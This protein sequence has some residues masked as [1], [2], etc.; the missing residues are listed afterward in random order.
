VVIMS[1]SDVVWLKVPHVD[2]TRYDIW[3]SSGTY[4]R[5]FFDRWRKSPLSFILLRMPCSPPLPRGSLLGG[6]G[7]REKEAKRVAIE[8]CY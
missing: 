1:D 5:N 8:P 4:P 3:A 7:G 6:G 2:M